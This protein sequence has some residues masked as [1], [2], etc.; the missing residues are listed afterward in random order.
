MVLGAGVEELFPTISSRRGDTLQGLPQVPPPGVELLRGD[1]SIKHPP[2][3]LVDQEAEGQEC[4]L[5]T[6]TEA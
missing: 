6:I 3:V 5:R 1:G 2:A 4:D